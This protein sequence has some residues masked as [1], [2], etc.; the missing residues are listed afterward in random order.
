MS[1]SQTHIL[2]VDDDREF[3]KEL[4]DLLNTVYKVYPC[5]SLE[6]ARERLGDRPYS[7]LLVDLVFGNNVNKAD[8]IGFISDVITKYP[9]LPVIAMTQYGHHK[10][11][12]AAIQAGAK[13]VLSKD[14]SSILIWKDAIDD[15]LKKASLAIQLAEEEEEQ[16]H[17]D[18][19]TVQKVVPPK[20]RVR[21]ET[22]ET[23]PFLGDNPQIEEIRTQ[24]EALSEEPDITV[25]ILGETG[26]GKEVAARFL[27]HHGA[28]KNKPFETVHLAAMTESV[29]ESTLFGHKKGAFTDAK[30]DQDGVFKRANNG[31]LFL[32]EIGEISLDIQVKL[33]RFLETKVIKPLG[34]NK[35]IQ[36][37]VQIVTATNKDLREEVAAGRFREDLYFRLCDFE[38][39]IPPLRERREDIRIIAD[40]YLAQ[41]Q[42]QADAFDGEVW[43]QFQKYH[44]PG[45]VRELVKLIKRLLLKRK[46]TKAKVVDT[47]FLPDYFFTK[48]IVAETEVDNSSH[49][50]NAAPQAPFPP[51]GIQTGSLAEQTAITELQTIESALVELRYKSKVVEK[52]GFENLDQ[53]R[54]RINK[55][56]SEFPHL[57]EHF[58]TIYDK[59]KLKANG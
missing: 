56:H 19:P 32:D 5:M 29:M 40:H 25:L 57:F 6:Q 55:Y 15:E 28:R 59:Y 7:L 34:S 2:I 52:L 39:N 16:G 58:P 31:V 12:V 43:Q 44:W 51:V 50:T 54:Y 48:P 38:I 27:H 13:N 23:H 3:L 37:D 41:R 18:I 20:E 47:S 4:V 14:T 17:D 33:L 24:L 8:G 1:S 22:T 45:N 35:E 9:D 10:N 21:G 46:I 26:V 30:A 11:I 42:A 53:L 36:L 49:P